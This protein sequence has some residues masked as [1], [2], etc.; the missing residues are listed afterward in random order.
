MA[1]HAQRARLQ[2]LLSL[3]GIGINGSSPWDITVHHQGFYARV[4]R[5]GSLGL[6]ESYMDGWWDCPALDQ[7]F[8]RIFNSGIERRAA[9]SWATIWLLLR[10]WM[11][12]AQSAGRSLS[13]IERHYDLGNDLFQ[14][15]LDARMV[16]TSGRWEQAANLDQAQEA[17]LDYVCRKLNL[18]PGMKVL[19]VGCGWGSFARFAAER[20]GVE[21]I[22]ITLSPSQL[23]LGRVL[24]AGLPIELRLEDYREVQERFDRVVSLGMFEHVG[25]RNYGT[26]F[27]RIRRSL[28]APH[29]FYLSTIGSARSTYTTDPWFERYIFPNSHI[30][31]TGQIAAAMEGSFAVEQWQNWADDYDRTLMAWLQNFEAHW[32]QLKTRYS[33]RFRRMWRYYLLASA[34]AFRSRRLQVWQMVLS[35]VAT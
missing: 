19:D 22:G 12:N 3:A 25:Q 18:A 10:S 26:F 9:G 29:S 13:S 20:Y 14:S 30:P 8:F 1:P 27:K 4:L 34:A 21:V 7:F 33:E 5:D 2:E 15:M 23:E 24:C 16:Y 35:P 17:K 6:G 31:S 32:D 11:S 28:R